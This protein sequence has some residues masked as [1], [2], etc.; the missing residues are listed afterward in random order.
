M[1]IREVAI[2]QGTVVSRS[3]AVPDQKTREFV[4]SVDGLTAAQIADAN[5][6]IVIMPQEQDGFASGRFLPLE[7]LEWV[8]GSGK[9]IQLRFRSS[10]RR[11]RVLFDVSRPISFG[12]TLT[13]E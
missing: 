5:L 1:R 12:A 11:V 10:A 4:V 3:V 6:C 9:P 8:G 13:W 7:A 2:D